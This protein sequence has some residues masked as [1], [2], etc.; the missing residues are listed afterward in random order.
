MNTKHWNDRCSRESI[1]QNQ[2]CGEG[3]IID[4]F[5][6]DRGHQHG[7]EI[8]SVTQ[9]A[10]IIVRNAITNRLVTKLIARPG[11][12][13]RYYEKENRQAPDWL[14]QLAYI[15]QQEGWNKC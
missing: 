3:K 1:I 15:H 11:Q 4:E 8:H 2:L 12:I 13:S 9:N 10:I 5:Y 14:I 6:V 7:P